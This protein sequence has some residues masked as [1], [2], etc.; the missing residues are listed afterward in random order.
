MNEGVQSFGC[1]GVA[2]LDAWVE[3]D[4]GKE[5]LRQLVESEHNQKVCQQS[6]TLYCCLLSCKTAE[7]P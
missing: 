6:H 1:T 2:L 3:S 5:S 7:V 4:A